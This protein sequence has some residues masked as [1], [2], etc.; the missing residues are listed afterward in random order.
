LNGTSEWKTNLPNPK[1][2]NPSY[3]EKIPL[4]YFWDNDAPAFDGCWEGMDDAIQNNKYLTYWFAIWI[5][6]KWQ[7]HYFMYEK[8]FRRHGYDNGVESSFHIV[9]DQVN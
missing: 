6:Y 3:R 5:N 7:Q 1:A 2:E 9:W 4:S 8:E